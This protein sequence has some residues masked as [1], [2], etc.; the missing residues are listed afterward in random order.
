LALAALFAITVGAAAL[1][2][3]ALKRQ[4]SEPL[5]PPEVRTAM[6]DR[7]YAEAIAGLDG[8]LRTSPKE[9]D[10]WL[11]LK[12]LA[13]LYA[14]GYEGAVA[15]LT[16]FERK[17]PASR[18]LAKARFAR[19]EAHLATRQYQQAEDIYEAEAQRLMA[20][21]RKDELAGVLVSFADRLATPKDPALP[22]SPEPDYGRAHELYQ[23]ALD[24]E[25]SPAL[26]D[27]VMFRRA[28]TMVA[29]KNWG[30]ATGEFQAYLAE[31]DPEWPDAR[32]G[33]ARRGDHIYQARFDLADAFQQAGQRDEARRVW[34][35]LVAV[36]AQPAGKP[37]AQAGAAEDAL[38]VQKLR[39]S[40]MYRIAG[41]YSVGDLS[42]TLMAVKALG[43]ALAAYPGAEESVRS[44][45]EIGADYQAIGRHDDAVAAYRRF[46]AGTGFRP[47]SAKAEEALAELMMEAEF[48]L[49]NVYLA[50]KKYDDAKEVWSDYIARHPAGPQWSLCQQGIVEA[51]YRLGSDLM[52]KKDYTSAREA[53]QA[54]LKQYPLE[55]RARQIMFAFG[56]MSYQ[57]AVDLE[58][59]EPTGT[60]KAGTLYAEA[61]GAWEKL[62]SKYPNSEESS[63]AQ[64]M[65][66]LVYETKLRDL[67]KAIAEYGKCTWGSHAREAAQR[68][69]GMT[70]RQLTLLTERVW[71][72]D[73]PARVK[74]QMRNVEKLT[75]SAYRLDLE[76]YFRK[77]QR[78]SGVEELDTPLIAADKTWEVEAAGYA[79]YKPIEQE[80]EIPMEKG[81]PG[82]FAVR[83][84]G[85]QLQ[86]TTLVIRSDLDI[87]VKSSKKGL[88]VFAEN[89][90][91]RKSWPDARIVVSDGQKVF[92]EGRAG[93]DGVLCRA[94]DELKAAGQVSVL[95]VADGHVA[96]NALGIGQLR[97]SEGLSP[98]GY[99]YTD[100]P[101]YRPGQVVYIRAVLREVAEGSYSFKAGEEYVT[102]VNDSQG[103][104]LATERLAL[105]EFGTANY[106]FHLDEFAPVGSYTVR[107]HRP[108]GPV[109]SGTFEVRSYK[110][111]PIELDIQL[112]EKIVFRGEPL[113]GKMVARYYYGEPLAGR[114][115]EYWLP[116]GRRRTAITDDK[117]EAAFT[118]D[119]AAMQEEQVL[120]IGAGIPGENVRAAASAFLA[121]RAYKASVSVLRDVQLSGEPFDVSVHAADVEDKPVSRELALKVL[122][123][124]SAPDGTWAEVLAFEKPVT[125]D[126]A[127]GDGVVSVTLEAGGQYILRAEGQDRFKNPISGERQVYV[128]DD[129]DATKLRILADRQH[130][131]VGEVP[132]VVLH[133]RLERA[134]ALLTFEGEEIISYRLVELRRGR[135][136][137]EMPIGNEH[138]PNFALG[139]C[140]M[141][142]NT[143]H[144]ATQAFTVERELKVAVKPDKESYGPGD[145]ARVEVFTTDQNG[146]PVSAELS[147][148]MVDESL[149]GIYPD[150]T[151]AI[152]DFFEKGVRRVAAMA[153]TTS[154]TFSYQPPTVPVPEAL[155]TEKER[156]ERKALEE[157]QRAL[158]VERARASSGLVADHAQQVAAAP[159]APRGA[160]AEA[161]AAG[162]EAEEAAREGA[163]VAA[164]GKLRADVG[165][166]RA[167][168]ASG[169]APPAVRE[170]LPETA[171]WNPAVVTDAGG[172]A[173]VTITMPGSMTKWRLTARGATAATLV[174]QQ[175]AAA[176]T[177]RDFFVE[178]K[179]P[180]V[181]NEGDAIRVTCRVHNLTEY[182]GPA[183]LRLHIEAAAA[184]QTL[185]A[186]VELKGRGIVEHV[187]AAYKVPAADTLALRLE[188]TAG[189]QADALSRS[190]PVRPWGLELADSSSGLVDDRSAFDLA[191]PAGR[192]YTRLAMSIRVDAGL[193]QRLIDAALSR[194]DISPRLESFR[195]MPTQADA[196]SELLGVASVMGYLQAQ[197]Q[198][199]M[200]EWKALSDRAQG[201]IATL[202]VT[203][204]DGGGWPWAGPK[205][206]QP[207]PYTSSRAVWALGEARKLGSAVPD[208]VMARAV[209]YLKDAYSKAQ[210]EDNELK[211]CILHALAVV[212][213]ADFGYANRL[214]RAR[215]GLSPSA[216]AHTA[217]CL[218]LLERQPMAADVLE[219]LETKRQQ[220]SGIV[221][222]QSR[223]PAAANGPWTRS[224]D[225]M[226]ALAL[227]AYLYGRPDAPAANEAAAY[228]LGRQP[229]TPAGAKGP[230]LAALSRW[231]GKQEPAR[232][233]YRLTVSVNGKE[234]DSV[235]VR[236]AAPARTIEVPAD[237]IK[238]GANRV[239]LVLQG[240]GRPHYIAVLTG[241]SSDLTS[242]AGASPA[243]FRVDHRAY[244]A[245]LPEHRGKPVRVGFNVLQGSYRQWTNTVSQLPVGA[246][247]QAE[248]VAYVNNPSGRAEAEADYLFL[249]EPLPAGATVLEGSV[250]GTFEHYEV[251]DNEIVFLLGRRPY[252]VE[253]FY[254]LVGYATGSYRV[255]PSAVM[256]A[257][258]GEILVVGPQASLAVLGPGEKSAD[259]YDPTPDELY[260]LGKA[261]FDEGL[262]AE[263]GPR[264]E[265]LFEKWHQNLRDEQY[266]E[267]ARML[268]FINIEKGDAPKIV[269]Y[270]EVMK[271]KYPSLFIPFDKVL[272][273]GKAYK[274]M[275]EYE[276]AMLVF[277]ATVSASFVK[278]AHVGGVLEAQGQVLGSIAFM[279]DLW[280]TYPDTPVVMA[281]YLALSDAL[282]GLAPRALEV[283][284]LKE[285]GVTRD[286][287][288]LDAI[289]IL[290]QYLTHYPEDPTADDAALNLVN[291]YLKL[292]DFES[293]VSLCRALRER[294]PQSPFLDSFEYVEALALW[295]LGNHDEAIALAR[296]VA[297]TTYRLPDGTDSPSDN[298]DLALYI[299]AQIWHAR[300]RP[301]EAI[302]YYGKVKD[303]FAD[304]AEAIDYFER[305]AV[306]LEEVT[307]FEPGEDVSTKLTYRNIPDV[308]LLVYRVDLM[309]LYLSEKNLSRITQVKLAGIHPAMEP[310]NVQL[311]DGKDY[312]D[313]EKALA[314]DIRDS[315]A[316]LVICRGGDLYASGMV[317]VTP[318]KLEVQE[319]K[320]SG[321]VRVN[322]K[323]KKTGQYLKG[324]DV[325]VIGSENPDFFSGETDLR[326]IFVADSVR[327]TATVIAR[328]AA[329][330]FAFYHGKEFLGP[331]PAAA[332][333]GETAASRG[334]RK[335]D[336]MSN[337]EASNETLQQMRLG[338]QMGLYKA[339]QKGV[340]V[341]Q[342]GQ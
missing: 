291:A 49:G 337:V 275:E 340:Q 17:H 188:A 2:A 57:A 178:M 129:K 312:A 163:Q 70:Q 295:N 249:I 142:D 83:V 66:G 210:Q 85:G 89:M 196:A 234:V 185:S 139:A 287:L 277:K 79:K 238:A 197:G 284:E 96:S 301:A 242:P 133:S 298:K 171:Y 160:R 336:Y 221:P 309:T 211:A 328:D 10:Y 135:N 51:E 103:R 31:F 206:N 101:A 115:L 141:T 174:G 53:W 47:G 16:E 167:L 74:V 299:V 296:K 72:T 193:Q 332:V 54:F 223:W 173:I 281:S 124:V 156:L 77:T 48:R 125:T 84:S 76:D 155:I 44:A 303:K 245:A 22:D 253:V 272:A 237:L 190:L 119:T 55:P 128:S 106:A 170:V 255:L 40:A 144:E 42:Q 154:C 15:S 150:T 28:Q 297:D 313:K 165:V 322:I 43:D 107:C 116:D 29:A 267:T 258:S 112:K 191:L 86:A 330:Q 4:P 252:S 198:P 60:A 232:D 327:G 285:K 108:N 109:F 92:F 195:P 140:A 105:G 226:T 123:R 33:I 230:A 39:A 304:A 256:G 3:E 306:S 317:L 283:P 202:V 259:A 19:A 222:A 94:F 64:Y 159:M 243:R 260:F 273:V 168:R 199:A 180:S 311:G 218:A 12:G 7:R 209:S 302:E 118:F 172:K 324:V 161:F 208:E 214:H 257:S 215:Q 177:K 182:V 99:I 131:R 325:K 32:A 27:E 181:V 93:D 68:I 314:L 30:S 266:R 235:Q 34:Q 21:G 183:E 145:E 203:Q 288:M 117:G 334:G 151:P 289:E 36:T 201:L 276:R 186:T 216:L 321:R 134:L 264:L 104:V 224:D 240:R 24:F 88:L 320:T 5:V 319:D 162:R 219:V 71:R 227:L 323:D 228:L 294:F 194:G 204:H 152:R 236:G 244:R 269:R 316:Y 225:E 187:F 127:T 56:Q 308:H 81:A 113:E 114:Q 100:R 136:A 90:A 270:F 82:V 342:M 35:D 293:V 41:T 212:G 138:F 137:V 341:E 59:E 18:W 149:L 110:L 331:P 175:T 20:E 1:A 271:E 166:Q 75:V 14:K 251:R 176:V 126:G 290:V 254:T 318:L 6:H 265:S 339:Q 111:E 146:Q 189:K 9:G 26:R 268:L 78:I 80:I 62:V 292:E 300:G 121:I 213:E 153:T 38:A 241:F 307:T 184:V 58:K 73:E 250:H 97:L 207:D 305:K 274:Q 262:Y 45:F 239:E 98:R 315:G 329:G 335:V 69:A 102:E 326:G 286:T 23:A 37:A 87:I 132:T 147:L 67:E 130:F 282:Y 229:W 179:L 263:A 217:I 278:D 246:V 200:P 8:L 91:Q 25:T 11:Y 164:I 157:E 233:D 280:R 13:Q 120:Q 220:V 63:R 310:L 95:A 65:I 248:T 247:T 143:F 169:A 50:Q 158:V 333:T 122:K 231:F 61:V 52:A 261:Y 338:G 148:A 205:G 46:L 279:K 192:T